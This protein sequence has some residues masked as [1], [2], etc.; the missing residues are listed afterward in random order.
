M[1][2]SLRTKVTL[3][4][5]AFG[6]IPAGIIA[7]FAYNS[8]QDFMG[9]QK[10]MIRQAAVA[11]SDHARLLVQKNN[12][13]ERKG[14]E[15]TTENPPPLK[16]QLTEEDVQNLQRHISDTVRDYNLANT[17]VYLVD[18]KNILIIQRDKQN[19]FS[20]NLRDSKL[21]YKYEKQ[22]DAANFK[23]DTEPIEAR[24]ETNEPAEIVGYAPVAGPIQRATSTTALTSPAGTSW[25]TWPA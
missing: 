6:L 7:A 21:P 1:R 14:K 11:I 23:N 22:A 17:T 16:W 25:A 4:L 24:P 5:V 19:S 9:R 12:E 18:P 8:A 10:L 2:I 20:S 13:L 15:V 3:A